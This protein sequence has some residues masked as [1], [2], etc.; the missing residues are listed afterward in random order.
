MN[1][2]TI[3]RTKG[4]PKQNILSNNFR[5]LFNLWSSKRLPAFQ[6]KWYPFHLKVPLIMAKKKTWKSKTAN[7]LMANNKQRKVEGVGL[8]GWDVYTTR[9][10]VANKG[11]INKYLISFSYFFYL[12]DF[13]F[14][15]LLQHCWDFHFWLPLLFVFHLRFP[16]LFGFRS[17][18]VR[19]KS[20]LFVWLVCGPSGARGV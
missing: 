14:T 17:Q 7:I 16:I 8:R 1:N 19:R 20:F 4:I 13:P 2:L 18:F 5:E 6:H 3:C 12:A 10:R 15:I 9:G 11:H